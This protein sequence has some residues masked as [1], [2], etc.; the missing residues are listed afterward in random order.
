MLGPYRGEPIKVVKTHHRA[1]FRMLMPQEALLGNL[2]LVGGTFRWEEEETEIVL[3]H[4]SPTDVFVDIGANTGYYTLLA[5]ARCRRVYAF[6]PGK[7]FFR[8]LLANLSLN[9]GANVTAL[10]YGL[11]SGAHEA[12]LKVSRGKLI[13]PAAASVKQS[14]LEAINRRDANFEKIDLRVFDEVREELGIPKVDFL[15]VD[16]E[17]AEIDVLLGMRRTLSEEHPSIL[18][19]VHPSKL[20]TFGRRNDDLFD[21]LRKFGYEFRAISGIEE[22]VVQPS[23]TLNST[24]FCW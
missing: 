11:F 10:N 4:L 20:T 2:F 17:G 22:E 15:K 18:L 9:D 5:Q 14:D 16:V 8:E 19:S 23:Y 7:Q 1:G 13:F 12:Y 3:Q 21:L 6:E 24:L